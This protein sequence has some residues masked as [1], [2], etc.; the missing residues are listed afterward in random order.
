M[1][2]TSVRRPWDR[3]IHIYYVDEEMV[4][5][6][7][8]AIKPGDRLYYGLFCLESKAKLESRC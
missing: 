7:H 2:E 3:L 6:G 4:A 8:Y 5:Q 1:V